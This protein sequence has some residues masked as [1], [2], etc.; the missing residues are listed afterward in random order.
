MIPP[1]L[2]PL[3]PK[4]LPDLVSRV[5]MGVVMELGVIMSPGSG[6]WRM[7]AFLKSSYTLPSVLFSHPLVERRGP[8]C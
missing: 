8:K 3:L 1:H 6:Q 5:E 7:S 2:L 4:A